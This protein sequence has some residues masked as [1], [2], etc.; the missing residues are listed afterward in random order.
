MGKLKLGAFGAAPAE[1]T[2]KPPP[3]KSWK[4]KEKKADENG[5]Q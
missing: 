4:K 2:S 3:K 5:A 1:D